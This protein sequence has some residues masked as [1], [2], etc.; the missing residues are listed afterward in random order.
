[1]HQQFWT[2]A[3]WLTIIGLGARLVMQSRR[4]LVDCQIKTNV[5][6]RVKNSPEKSIKIPQIQWILL[7]LASI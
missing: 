5:V 7:I 1:M 6:E 4:R 2:N 3:N